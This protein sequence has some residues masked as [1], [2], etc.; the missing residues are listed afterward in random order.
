M[1]K[2]PLPPAPPPLLILTL[3][4]P[5]LFLT[6]EGAALYLSNRHFFKLK[7]GLGTRTNNHAELLAL[8]L[9]LQFA[10]EKGIQNKMK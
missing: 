10:G 3:Q 6:E 7:I 5:R 1:E 2:L 9:L 8:K 4:S